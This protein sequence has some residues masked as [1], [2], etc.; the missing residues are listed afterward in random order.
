MP[1]AGE[2]QNINLGFSLIPYRV[3]ANGEEEMII[4]HLVGNNGYL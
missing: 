4:F 1:K 2:R 3:S